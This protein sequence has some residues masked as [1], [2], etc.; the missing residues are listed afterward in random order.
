MPS[1]KDKIIA[2]A[3]FGKKII[4]GSVSKADGETFIVDMDTIESI[5]LMSTGAGHIATATVSGTTVTVG[6]KNH[7]GTAVATAETIYYI[8]FGK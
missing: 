2:E 1:D 6:L 7:D 8:A 4:A 5:I 3:G